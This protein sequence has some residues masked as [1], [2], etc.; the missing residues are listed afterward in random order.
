MK[1]TFKFGRGNCCS[2]NRRSWYCNSNTCDAF[3]R[4]HR[5]PSPSALLTYLSF[6]QNISRLLIFHYSIHP[7]L[8]SWPRAAFRVSWGRLQLQSNPTPTST[9]TPAERN[10]SPP[11]H[12]D[13]AAPWRPKESSSLTRPTRH[14]PSASS[15][16]AKAFWSS[17]AYLSATASSSASEQM[18]AALLDWSYKQ[19]ISSQTTCE[20]TARLPV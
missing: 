12:L 13:I 14:R 15:S 18:A 6:H 3:W 1:F 16:K 9:P 11:K 17:N 19:T 5:Y 8:L 10:T 7:S 4:M 20:R 2:T